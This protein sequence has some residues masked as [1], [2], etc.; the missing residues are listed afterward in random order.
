MKKFFTFALVFALTLTLGYGFAFA[1]NDAPSGKH[2]NLNIIGVDNPK[3]A[4]MT[5]SNRHTIFVALGK[6]NASV[7]TRIYL[8]EGEFCVCDG[9]GFDAAYS[10]QVDEGG[11]PIVIGRNY[12]AVFQLPANGIDATTYQVFVRALGTPGGSGKITTCV[13]T[14]D[15][16]GNTIDACS[17]ESVELPFNDGKRPAKFQNVTQELTTIVL[18][19]DIYKLKGD[20]WTVVGTKDVRY[21]LFEEDFGQYF[22]D[23]DNAGL[24]LVQLRFYM[25]EDIK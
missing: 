2:Y 17:S 25:N 5:G 4:D 11:D 16:D 19:E 22:W 21:G 8:T 23:Y 13:E 6:K 24:K 10:C 15:E 18:E 9:N 14:Y 1:G 12:G 3:T 20:I 7:A